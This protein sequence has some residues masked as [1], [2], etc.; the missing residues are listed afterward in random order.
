MGP[1]WPKLVPDWLQMASTNMKMAQND[2][3]IDPQNNLDHLSDPTTGPD[4]G[5][6]HLT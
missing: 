2:P 1:K 4:H 5:P 3:E 6:Q